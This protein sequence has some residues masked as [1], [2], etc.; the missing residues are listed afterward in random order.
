M[1]TENDHNHGIAR[2]ILFFL[3]FLEIRL[4][5]VLILLITALVVG[6]WDNIQNYYERWQRNRA[7][8]AGHA[9]E[10]ETAAQIQSE[11]EYTCAMH[12]FVVRDH[13]GKCPICGMDLIKRKK[14]AQVQLPEG[15]LARVQV[16][17]ERIMQA[18][19]QIEP[20]AYRLLMRAVRT[21]GV[22]ETDETRVAK[23]VARFPG[24]IDELMV[25]SVGLVV[26][27]GEPLARI[28]SP[29]FLAA[30]QEYLQAVKAERQA[31][32]DS[33]A[34]A[35]DKR[36][37]GQLA[38][39]AR[40]RLLLAGFTTEQLNGIREQGKVSESVTLNSPLAG[41]VLE[42]NALPGQMVE[43]GS[44][45]YTIADLS[46]VWVQALTIE[47]DLSAVNVGM[48]VEVTSVSWPGEIFYG[49]VDFIYPTVDLQ[50]RSVKVRVVVA[51]PAG[52]LKPGM[53]VMAVM[54]S[55]VGRYGDADKVAKD[56]KKD[57]PITEAKMAEMGAG[58]KT[59]AHAAM[60]M[61]SSAPDLS[62]Q[63]SKPVKLPTE[64]QAD[65]D[66]FLARL[67]PGAEYYHC[68]MDP[69]V[70][71]DKPG[72]CPKCGMHLAKANKERKPEPQ[73][74]EGPAG[75]GQGRPA[76][77]PPVGQLVAA[78]A[79]QPSTEQ[80]AEG[81]SCEMH[82]D[83]LSDKPGVCSICGCGM[84]LKKMRIERVPSIPESAVVDTGTRQIVYV[85]SQPG[86]YDAREVKL[87]AR[88]GAFYP[89]LSG[90]KL[91]DKIVARGSFLIDAEARLNPATAGVGTEGAGSTG[92]ENKPA[93]HAGHPHGG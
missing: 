83:E 27:K 3:K 93:E 7:T 30:T 24:R 74:H 18:G 90:L 8:P 35:D 2:K 13:P 9:H 12:P 47:S 69:E 68:T 73:G 81:Y 76:A 46:T 36:R 84:K 5:F 16:S 52:K 40:Q 71:S 28:Y 48:P 63:P 75:Q 66:A 32:M 79:D 58:E 61:D 56:T 10:G 26:K 91:G 80:W 82:P 78:R 29:K 87:G 43:E 19:V 22:I 23:I 59:N 37:A 92:G 55:P 65:A 70:V 34:S 72:D 42:K 89:V 1:K 85:E 51:N 54:R 31:N 50:N 44:T 38:E 49:T 33:Q 11:F 67:A 57:L 21:Y 86:V 14:G 41:T 53:Y 77:G 15:T 25:N 60:K 88:A 6:Y 4:R 64:T 17:P 20:V 62:K 39:F 45:L